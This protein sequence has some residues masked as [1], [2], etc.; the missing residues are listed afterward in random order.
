MRG[1]TVPKGPA[2]DAADAFLAAVSHLVGADVDTSSAD[3]AD[4]A[5]AAWRAV[6]QLPPPEVA[7]G[8]GP[9]RLLL[10]PHLDAL[11]GALGATLD[12]GAV[13]DLV[14]V[15]EQ[16]KELAAGMAGS[17]GGGGGGS[18]SGQQGHGGQV[19]VDQGQGRE[20]NKGGGTRGCS[21]QSATSHSELI[22]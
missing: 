17:G 7:R 2:R 9:V 6:S 10:G 3:L 21:A 13:G 1:F 19:G 14:K 22:V 15:A 16:M 8:S 4:A 5:A 18:S 20:G 12:L 11:R